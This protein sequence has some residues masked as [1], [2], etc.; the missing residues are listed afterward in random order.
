VNAPS[1]TSTASKLIARVWHGVTPAAK[2]EAYT[3]YL[4]RTGVRDY[5]ASP[6][7]RGVY[8]LRRIQGDRAEFTLITLWDSLDA[9]RGFAGADYEKARYY[10]EDRDFLIEFEPFVVHHDVLVTP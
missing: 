5:R 1:P 6:G 9:I 3:E 7:N 4:H 10:P 2:A 8:M